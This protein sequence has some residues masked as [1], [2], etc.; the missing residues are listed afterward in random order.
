MREPTG[1]ATRAR[2]TT[3][4][5]VGL[6]AGGHS[7]IPRYAAKLIDAIDGVSGEYP[8]LRLTLTT[9]AAGAAAAGAAN[10]EVDVVGGTGPRVNAGPGRLLLEQIA[11]RRSPADLLYFFDTTGPVLAP[12]RPFVTT[13]HDMAPVLGYRR[14]QNA[15]KRRLYPWALRR[16]RASVAVS[17]FARDEAV[18]HLGI[19]PL[20]V[21]VIHSGP[22]LGP[23]ADSA[24]AALPAPH[25]PFV[26]YVGNLG[27]NKNLPL[28]VRAFHAA[29]VPARLVLAGRAREGADEVRK[30]VEQGPRRDRIE[31]VTEPSDEELD[32]LY[33]TALALALPS[34]YEG[35]GFTPLEAMTRGCPVL[36]SD[37]PAIREV[38]A[39]G[40]LLLP[41]HDI[42]AW[43][44]ALS[45]IV[46]DEDLRAELS[47][48]GR[49]TASR[50]SWDKT[51]RGVLE[52]LRRIDARG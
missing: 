9:T 23:T 24:A 21:T 36:A 16:A 33:R 19:D 43:A 51:A 17:A 2:H 29:D 41:P 1:S 6:I 7:G 37:I 20:S 8:E 15:Y 35:F 46:G 40:A 50:F 25:T 30:V 49:A 5:L 42:G 3:V 28:L 13:I 38:A 11:A 47:T 22:G 12:R 45:R 18:R 48:R 31:F 44:G 4:C 52:L 10:I 34:T 26:L 32:V 39:S 14:F 27:V